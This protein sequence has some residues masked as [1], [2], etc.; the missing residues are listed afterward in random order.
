MIINKS[1]ISRSNIKKSIIKPAIV[2]IALVLSLFF[3]WAGSFDALNEI[4][5]DQGL[6][7][8]V[9]NNPRP[10]NPRILKIDLNDSSEAAFG[11]SLDAREPF[12]DVLS[13]LGNYG[14]AAGL[15]FIFPR[16]KSGDE[17]M[18]RA[19]RRF[20]TLVYAVIPVIEGKDSFVAPIDE[21][22]KKIL[23]DHLWHIKGNI[24]KIPKALSFLMSNPEISASAAMLGHISVYPEKDGVFRRA[25]LLC[26]WEDGV[27]P[28]LPLA[29]AVSEL[30]IDPADIEFDS[31]RGLILPMGDS[32]SL[33]I[34]CDSNGY[35]LIPYGARWETD[36][37]RFS[38]ADLIAA[39]DPSNQSDIDL[40][41]ELYGAI[42]ILADITTGK[43]DFGITPFEPVFPLSGIHAAV[44]SGI[45]DETFYIENHSALKMTLI[46]ILF[47]HL[48]FFCLFKKDMFFHFG[49]ALLFICFC[50]LTFALW[51]WGNRLPWFGVGAF[52][53]LASWA[54]GFLLRLFVRY[55]EQ[56]L[57][58]TALSR[59][60]PSALAQRIAAEGKT[61]LKPAF[62]ELTMLFA[63]IAG[64]TRWS[65]DKEPVMV[66]EF[67]TD[68]LESMASI[69]FENGGTVDKFMGDGIL[70]FF[71]DP[72]EQPDHAKRCVSA[73]IQM[74]KKA[75]ELNAK[76]RHIGI[77]F[78]I[79][80]GL[81]SGKVI[82]G[83]LGTKTRIEYT[84]IG[85]AV[86]LAQRMESNAPH[87][88]ILAAE[89][90]WQLTRDHFSYGE[91]RDVAVKGYD[92]PIYAY[93]V[94]LD[95]D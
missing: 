14:A 32:A 87:G 59:Y 42:A 31:G 40:F 41:S 4:L 94:I 62:K 77:D 68:Y 73:A 1:I 30:G 28:S 48:L 51:N 44:L 25:S 91:K 58:Q 19:A 61:E 52:L 35:L 81:N 46:F 3:W 70:A 24:E 27:I 89:P 39:D 17:N 66:H 76:W 86:N 72:F 95:L 10:L 78:K 26:R 54:M 67:L 53:I 47:L 65:S 36:L 43:R 9:A 69:L 11:E 57:Y 93:E 71:G 16:S 38:F 21:A 75:R 29:L 63:D 56:L 80:I 79:R 50:F 49:H 90:A 8:R 84:V 7:Y 13:I 6:R 5:Y 74:Q 23:R 60:F 22:N 18:I 88:G 37:Y 15:D 82:V 12:G 33:V 20:N 2:C 83:N 34:P 92:E 45:L 85:S 64:F 55:R